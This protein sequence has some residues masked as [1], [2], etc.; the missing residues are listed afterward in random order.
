MAQQNSPDHSLS[1]VVVIIALMM[2]GAWLVQDQP[3]IFLLPWKY[4]R[5]AEL[6]GTFQFTLMHQVLEHDFI[7]FDDK[8]A[9]VNSRVAFVFRGGCALLLLHALYYFKMSLQPAWSMEAY[10]DG[11]YNRFR[12]LEVVYHSPKGIGFKKTFPFVTVDLKHSYPDVEFP[13][14]M[15][16]MDYY[17]KYEETL[18]EELKLQ[19]GP[20][21][22]V[23]DRKIVWSDKYAEELANDC[24]RRIPNKRPSPEAKSW[25]EQAWQRCVETHK[26]ERT[27]A[28]GMLQSARDFGVLNATEM[29][30]I[31]RAAGHELKKG[32]PG[33]FYLWRAMISLGGRTAYAEG[34]GIICHYHF[35]R[36]LTEYLVTNPSDHQI[37]RFMRKKPWVNN[38][39]TSFSEVRDVIMNSPDVIALKQAGLLK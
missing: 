24:F 10:L 17:A 19:V 2:L 20:E 29:L 11:V 18:P 16:P 25:R 8:V 14:G 6:A 27:F 38:A 28:L 4:L 26:F 31:R 13:I 32:N 3:W 39:V 36:S 12:W 30:H 5:V 21:L 35:E 23:V 15:E 34:A 22:T 37:V 7:A 33:T 9:F 1:I